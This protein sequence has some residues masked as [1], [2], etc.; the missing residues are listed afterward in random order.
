MI[1]RPA[2]IALAALPL[3]AIALF[4]T[5]GVW[6]LQRRVWKLDL[7]ARTEARLAAPAGPAPGP[8][9]W[10]AIGEGDAYMRVQ[11]RGR[12]R[13]HADTLTQAITEIGGGY[14]VMTPFD[15]GAYTIFVNRGFV[16]A[17]QR[18]AIASPPAGMVEVEGLLRNTERRGGF[19]RHNAPTAER[20][21]SRDV[22]AIAARRNVTR[23]AP[24]FIDAAATG[25]V[26]WPRGGMTVVRFR[27]SHLV[28]ALTWFG[29][30][31]LTAAMSWRFLRGGRID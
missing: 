20:W 17:D 28:Y 23:P 25:T 22:A 11:A 15:T 18:S 6:Q 2:R 21:Y 24:Y 16:P 13:Q 27:N 9:R 26:G 30:A 3:A 7:I 4:L 8:R 10:P 19:L 12:Y 14:W 5:L 1:R 31:V 29:L